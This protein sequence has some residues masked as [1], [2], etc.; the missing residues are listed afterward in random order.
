V[1][2]PDCDSIATLSMDRD[3]EREHAGGRGISSTGMGPS[4]VA[5]HLPREDDGG[6]RGSRVSNHSDSVADSDA[7]TATVVHA[8]KPFGAV[9]VLTAPFLRESSGTQH[10]GLL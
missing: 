10:Q 2:L 3:G 8:R 5:L 9:E 4:S 1:T 7:T 6:S